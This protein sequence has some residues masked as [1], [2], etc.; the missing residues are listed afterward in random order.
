VERRST[1]LR[2]A[3]RRLELDHVGTEIAEQ[4][5]GERTRDTRAQLENAQVAKRSG[6]H[7]LALARGVDG[8]HRREVDRASATGQRCVACVW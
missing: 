7:G 8:E 5:P 1:A 6:S 4:H 2:I 3:G